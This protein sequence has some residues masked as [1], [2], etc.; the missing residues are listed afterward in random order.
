MNVLPARQQLATTLGAA[1]RAA[2][3]QLG[4]TQAEVAVRIGVAMEVYGRIER[5]VLLPNIQTVLNL[6][7]VLEAEPRALLGLKAPGSEPG[8]RQTAEDPPHVRRLTRLAR[9]LGEAEVL[10]LL[11]VAKAMVELSKERRKKP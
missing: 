2:R 10:A 4:L 8:P 3:E 1:A 5:G 7:H 6:C 9:E 11:A